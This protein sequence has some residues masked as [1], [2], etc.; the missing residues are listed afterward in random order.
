MM[1]KRILAAALATIFTV[2]SLTGCG[3]STDENTTAN[4]AVRYGNYPGRPSSDILYIGRCSCNS[5][6][7]GTDQRSDRTDLR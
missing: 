3:A 4:K 6:R 5:A 7:P 1:K 2:A